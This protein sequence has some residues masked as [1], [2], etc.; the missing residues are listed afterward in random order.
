MIIPHTHWPTPTNPTTGRHNATNPATTT[1]PGANDPDGTNDPGG[2]A[3]PHA[4]RDGTGPGPGHGATTGSGAAISPQATARLLCDARIRRI[5][6]NARSEILDVG[7][8]RRTWSTAQRAAIIVRDQHCRGPGCDRPPD[9]CHIHH[10]RWWSHNGPTDLDN[11][12]LLCTHHHRL[13]HEGGWSLHHDPHTGHATFTD[14]HGRTITTRPR[15]TPG[16]P[17]G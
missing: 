15:G 9:W 8:A 5:V 17:S 7:R 6:T 16:N 10:I 13:L 2:G 4:N 11:G 3:D 12:I 1:N 14:P